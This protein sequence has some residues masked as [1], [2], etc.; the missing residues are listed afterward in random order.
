[1]GMSRLKAFLKL[2]RE[3]LTIRERHKLNDALYEAK[4]YDHIDSVLKELGF[5]RGTRIGKNTFHLRRDGEPIGNAV[6][7]GDYQGM[8]V[9]PQIDEVEETVVSEVP[10]DAYYSSGALY[11]Q[12]EREQELDD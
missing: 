5:G 12:W 2:A 10:W 6:L 9:V 7:K 1:M 3:T 11:D 8:K 4:G